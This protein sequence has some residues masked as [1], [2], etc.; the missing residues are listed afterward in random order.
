MSG[1]FKHCE[2]TI[3]ED[4]PDQPSPI[5]ETD[6]CDG[7]E[8]RLLFG[9]VRRKVL[10]NHLQLCQTKKLKKLYSPYE[11]FFSS[12]KTPM[13]ILSFIKNMKQTKITDYFPHSS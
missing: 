11:D 7:E 12:R 4:N 2:F 8:V 10:M 1:C 13:I 9:Q 3:Q 6:N 5:D